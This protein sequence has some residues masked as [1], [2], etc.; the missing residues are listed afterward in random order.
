[1]V[2]TTITRDQEPAQDRSFDTRLVMTGLGLPGERVGVDRASIGASVRS[3][4]GI[5]G[6]AA[7]PAGSSTGASID[8]NGAAVLDNAAA[9]PAAHHDDG[10]EPADPQRERA[11]ARVARA[12]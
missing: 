11:T 10:V 7:H 12:T 5:A 1:M 4:A 2:P 3:S 8:I 9:A 6:T